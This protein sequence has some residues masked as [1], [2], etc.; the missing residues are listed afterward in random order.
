VGGVKM[1]IGDDRVLTNELL[2]TGWRTVFQP[3]ARVYTDAPASWRAFVRQ[4]VRWARSS[5]RETFLSLRWLWR[6]PFTLACF[7]HDIIVPF[8][9]FALIGL[10]LVHLFSGTHAI[11]VPLPL[12]VQ[13]CVAFV[14]ATLSLGV[15][16]VQHFR[17][18]PR[19][20]L[21]L[22][23]FVLR[24]TFL[25]PVLR[26]VGFSTMFHQSWRTRGRGATGRGGLVG[27]GV[28]AL[29]LAHAEVKAGAGT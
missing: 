20:W 18:F 17:R 24:V 29:G 23:A 13:I 5:Q 11:A 10:T 22:P 12:G 6:Y 9:I 1:E 3:T 27:D 15:R 2:R 16:Q 25:M 19:D 7:V 21:R 28:V 8:W 4:Q 14:G 26:I